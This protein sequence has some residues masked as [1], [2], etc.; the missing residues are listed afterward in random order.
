VPADLLKVD[1]RVDEPLAL[2]SRP[3]PLG[4]KR[5]TLEGEE[6]RL[7]VLGCRG[8]W[9]QVISARTGNAWIDKWCAKDEGCRG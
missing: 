6:G 8:N 3:S 5:A 7:R 1:S 2:Y 9:L 4:Q